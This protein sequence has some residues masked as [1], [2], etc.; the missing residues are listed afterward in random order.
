M[1]EE[2]QPTFTRK[3]LINSVAERAGMTRHEAEFVVHLVQDSVTRALAEGKRVQMI[4][5]GSLTPKKVES[6]VR[7]NPATNASVEV[8]PTA[9]V[10]FRPAQDLKD[11]ISGAKPL[12]EGLVTRPQVSGE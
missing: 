11:Y 3:D 10:S 4:K 6:S 2:R 8:G 5:L 12:P 7:R 1:M 9:R